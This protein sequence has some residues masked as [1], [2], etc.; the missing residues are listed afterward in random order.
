MNNNVSRIIFHVDMNCFYCSCEIAENNELA[1]KPIAVAHKDILDRGIILSPSYEARK[2]GIYATMKVS[3]AKRLCPELQVIEPKME[4]YN[5]YSNQFYQYLCSLSDKVLVEMASCDEAYVDVSNFV[6]GK[7]AIELADKI[8]KE[9]Y[10][11]Y[12]LPCSIGIAPNKYLAKMASDM[13][14][15]M[16]ITILRKRELPTLMWPLKIDDLFGIGKKTAPK[17]HQMGINTIGDFV[18]PENKDRIVT[19]FGINFYEGY[20]ERCYGIDDSPVNT[21]YTLS[22]S[23]SGSS[24]FMEDVANVNTLL[25]TLRVICNTI[26]YKLQKDNQLALNVGVQIRYSDFQTI[27]R[28]KPLVNPTNDEYVFF[29]ALKSVF[30]DYFDDKKTVR[31][32]GAFTNRLKEVQDDVKQISIFDDFEKLEKDQKI[33]TLIKEINKCTGS[34]NLKKGIK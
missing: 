1:G 19:E 31:L 3:E 21:E 9:I 23:V 25:D 29:R 5:S 20:Y 28:S 8:Q 11:F 2:Y 27:N 34:N 16:G 18:K 12:G 7:E 22:S 30:E 10:E 13:K 15:P 4:L 26:C 33:N 17:L 14:K 6:F 32:I 24:T